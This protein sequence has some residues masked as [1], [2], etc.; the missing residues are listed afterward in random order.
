MPRKLAIILL[1]MSAAWTCGPLGS[2]GARPARADDE[3]E[4]HL[5]DL[6]RQVEDR[7]I[8]VV[9]R[10]RLALEVASTLDRAAQSSPT[11]EARR[12]RWTEAIGLLDR[13]GA[14]NPGHPRAHEFSFQSAVYLWARAQSWRQQ[15]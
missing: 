12:A 5:E 14:R 8:S 15:E 10:E 2:I 9:K 1:L 13:F 3:M 4:K 11:A 6:R 7:T